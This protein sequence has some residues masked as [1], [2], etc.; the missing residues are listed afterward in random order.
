MARPTQKLDHLPEMNFPPDSPRVSK[1]VFLV[2][3]CARDRNQLSALKAATAE[4]GT[5]PI[6]EVRELLERL[7]TTDVASKVAQVALEAIWQAI[8][9]RLLSPLTATAAR[10]ADIA[11]IQAQVKAWYLRLPVNSAGR[12]YLLG[13]LAAGG[14]ADALQCFA[15]LLVDDPPAQGAGIGLAMAPLISLPQPH[16]A[17]LFPRMLEGLQHQHL[18]A[19]ILD[20]ANHAF[21][22]GKISP[23]P[24]RDRSTAL[25]G[26]LEQ[27]I[28][29]MSSLEQGQQPFRASTNVEQSV[30]GTVSLIVSLCHTLALIGDPAA[31]GPLARA[32]QLSHR[33]IRAEAAGALARLGDA[34]GSAAL[35]ELARWPVV[36]IRALA[37]ADELGLLDQIPAEFR[38]ATARAESELAAWLSEPTQF[39]LAPSEMKLLDRRELF[40]P[41]YS[42][43]KQ[44]FLFRFSYRTNQGTWS[45]VG[46]A[47]PAVHAASAPL[48]SLAVEDIYALFA[49]WQTTHDEIYEIDLRHLAERQTAAIGRRKLELQAE[50]YHEI[51]AAFVGRFFGEEFLIA[52]ARKDGLAGHLIWDL[53]ETSWRADPSGHLTSDLAYSIFKGRKLLASFNPSFSLP[54]S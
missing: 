22:T 26:V 52:T 46:I 48:E 2:G 50:G 43:P 32:L 51:A 5:W 21:A 34:A 27:L 11:E 36:R 6:G 53:R 28:D 41:G 38:S 23:H 47:G 9:T 42:E 18:A 10:Q 31:R 19:A 29:K 54:A 8:A 33:R 4:L 25:I 35:I 16:L 24:A 39:G 7:P 44:C 1:V 13:M 17:K 20:V 12:H 3:D 40:W 14:T 45:N 37:Y 30:E 15:D 49:G